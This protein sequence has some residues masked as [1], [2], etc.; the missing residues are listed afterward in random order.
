MKCLRILILLALFSN[1]AFAQ[2]PLAFYLQIENRPIL[3]F[4]N[5]IAVGGYGEYIVARKFLDDD[6]R[7]LTVTNF[8]IQYWNTKTGEKIR[9]IPHEIAGLVNIDSVVSISP[10]GRRMIVADGFNLSLKKL[11]GKKTKKPAVVYSLETGKALATL[12]RPEESIRRGVWTG[13]G[14]TLVTFSTAWGQSY[15]MEVCFWDGETLELRGSLMI[16]KWNYLTRRG[17]R[18]ITTAGRPKNTLG[19]KYEKSNTINVWNTATVKLEKTFEFDKQ[20]ALRNIRITPDEKRLLAETENQIVL[21]DLETGDRQFFA[22]ADNSSLNEVTLSGDKRFLAAKNGRKVLVWEVGGG[23]L[24]KFE[25]AAP[26][27]AAKEKLAV[28]LGGF[29]FDNRSVGVSQVEIKKA[30]LVFPWPKYLRTERYDVETGKLIP[31]ADFYVNPNAAALSADRRFAITHDCGQGYFASLEPMKMLYKFPLQCKQG[32]STSYDF[33]TGETK[34]ET[35]YYNDDIIAFHPRENAALV[36]KDNS[37]E[38]YG[39]DPASRLWQLVAAPRPLAK[40][41]TRG[42]FGNS[43]YELFANL[44]NLIEGV[45]ADHDNSSAGF[46]R[47]GDVVFAL[48]QDGR[49]VFF[50]DFDKNLV[51]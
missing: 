17:D 14:Q 9:T 23:R 38:I 35:Y 24:P 46:L 51:D 32:V 40:Q 34:E 43:P 6:D 1:L 29:S 42:T 11:L 12:Q 36:V 21:L 26:P 47:D 20:K 25:I 2:K 22:A 30:L 19:Y 41:Y 37:L 31:E 3:K 4:R 49:S 27:P 8:G 48:S 16:N 44:A 10:D 5:E 39:P 13:D 15:E 33:S 45:N 28:L 18:F 50:W 7:L